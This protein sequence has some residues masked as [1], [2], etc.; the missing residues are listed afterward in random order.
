M[1][2]FSTVTTVTTRSLRLPRGHYAVT[3]QSLRGYYAVTTRSLCGHYAVTTRYY[4][5]AR[6]YAVTTR[7]LRGSLYGPHLS[8]SLIHYTNRFKFDKS[9]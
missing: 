8:L 3:T 7:S 2:T 4:V 1:V 9:R 5:T 6:H